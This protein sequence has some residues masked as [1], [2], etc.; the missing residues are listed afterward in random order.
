MSH[1]ERESSILEFWEKNEIFEKSVNQRPKENQ[2]V[3]Y[4]GPPF[5]TGLPH[6]GNI[7]GFIS[8]DL[9][10]RYWTMKG[11]RCERRWGWDCHGLPIE[12]IAEI[13]LKIK[14]KKEILQ[15]GIGQ[16]NEFCRSRVLWYA[17]E[18]KEFV[19][20]MGKWIAFDDAYKT[21][22][23]TYMETVW[24]IFKTFYDKNLIYQGKRILLYCPRCETPLSK[25]EI[26]MDNSYKEVSE[27]TIVVKFKILEA[28]NHTYILAWTTTPWTLIGNVALAINSKLDYVKVNANDEF[29][30]L[31]KNALNTLNTPFEII[32]E[33]KGNKLIGL[34][35]EPLYEIEEVK[36]GYFIIDGVDGVTA[37][38]G[39][40]VVHLAAYGEFDM[41]MIQKHDLSFVQHISEDGRLI[42]GPSE[43]IGTWFKD[44]DKKVAVDLYNRMRLY[45]ID[46][47]THSYPFCYRCETPLIYNA[48]DSWFVDIQQIKDRLLEKSNAINWYPRAMKSAFEN[49]IKSAPDWNISRNRFWATAIPV[50]RCES[51]N[52]IKV[53]GSIKELQE[54]ALGLV[55]DDVDLHKHVVDD[56]YLQCQECGK[57]MVRIPEVLDCWL[58]SGSMPFAAMHYPFENVE[59]F[60]TNFPSDFVAEY[61]AQVRAWFY[62]ML[63]VS[64]ALVDQI[65][66]KNVVV[67]GV[68]LAADGKKMSKSKKNFVDPRKILEKFGGD[69]LRFYLFSS[70]VMRAE[71]ISFIENNLKETYKNILMLLANIKN[72]YVLFGKKNKTFNVTRSKHVMDQW[73]ISRLNVAIK[74]TTVALDEY[75]SVDACNEVS[76]LLGDVS[77]WYI[78]RSRDRFKDV[79]AKE[80][81]QAIRTLG[82]IL[83][84]LSKLVAPLMPFIAE[85]IYQQFKSVKKYLP[86]SVHLCDWPEYDESLINLDILEKMELVRKIVKLALETRAQEKIPIRQILS[87][88]VIKGVNLDPEYIEIVKAELNVKNIVMINNDSLSVELNTKITPD[89]KVEGICRDLIRN[90]NNYRKKLNLSFENRINLYIDTMDPEINECLEKFRDK[91][92]LSVQADTITK[93][94]KN[95]QEYEEIEINNGVIKIFIELK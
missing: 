26:T 73:I 88:L 22:D 15:L 31:T 87:D 6:Y 9:F 55:S 39:T 4:D 53:I 56:I 91:I 57:R 12:N 54:N 71:D 93:K 68:I 11:Y 85:D 14:E 33:F 42:K 46:D 1:I 35:Y 3:F 94:V 75:N 69:A 16:F 80:R 65:P 66:F 10:P 59:W 41:E 50:W 92:M 18:W 20:R 32:E 27:K 76:S 63:V 21:M 60:E 45:R 7:L 77:T 72:F 37:D 13:E 36:N 17:H 19:R 52:A 62:Y 40:G 29:L 25:F 47:Y 70:P 51:C 8:K 78:R 23:I 43:W 24:Y 95:A 5:A 64:V 28:E 44:L 74:N 84:N 67:S 58:E 30:I 90:L 2:F 81:S 49:V 48:I 61:I 83:M 82:Y 89:L 86:E 38:E 34:K 79:D